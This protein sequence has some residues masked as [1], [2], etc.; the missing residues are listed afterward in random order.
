MV[1]IPRI[2]ADSHDNTPKLSIPEE[3]IVLPVY[4][5]MPYFTNLL[6]IFEK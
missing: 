1:H 4:P 3:D 2:L 5:T 6:N